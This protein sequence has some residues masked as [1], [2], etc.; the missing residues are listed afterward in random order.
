MKIL[1]TLFLTCCS[2]YSMN[3]SNNSSETPRSLGKNSE[4]VYTIKGLSPVEF[5]MT[6]KR[7]FLQ[8]PNEEKKTAIEFS[9]RDQ[10]D[11]FVQFILEACMSPQDICLILGDLLHREVVVMDGNGKDITFKLNDEETYSSRRNKK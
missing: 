3:S 7:G 10:N 1:A 5:F 9:L 2:A 6:Q 11:T 8:C 4:Y